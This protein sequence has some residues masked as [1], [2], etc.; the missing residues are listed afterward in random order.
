MARLAAALLCL[1]VA[2]VAAEEEHKVSALNLGVAVMLLGSIGFM[3]GVFYMVNHSDKDM[4]INTWKVICSTISIFVAV[5]MFQA[6]NGI[7]KV[8]FLEGASEEKMLVAAF[9]HAGFWF[10]FLQFFLAFVSGAVELPCVT[11]HKQEIHDNPVLKQKAADKLFLDMKCWAII[12]G[13]I[14]GFA[15]IGAWC[16]AQQF[17]KHSIGLSF[18]IVPLAAFVTW[19]AYKVSDMIRYRIA[20]GD[21]GVEDEFE[22]AWDE[23]TEETEDDVM[24]LTVSFLLVQAI[25]FSVVGVLPNEE[26]NF[27]EDIT[28]SDYQ[29]FM[30]V[31][32]GV[33]VGVFHSCALCSKHLG[34]LNAWVRLVCDFVF[35]WSLMFAIEAYLATHGLGGSVMGCIGEVVQANLVTVLSFAIIFILDKLAD[36]GHGG[37][38]ANDA[39][40][41][42][43][44]ALGILIGFSWEKCFDTAVDNTAESG[45]IVFP[46]AI[47]KLL[48]AIVLAAIVVPAWRWYILPVVKELGGFEE[49]EEEEEEE[50]HHGH[51]VEEGHGHPH[52]AKKHE[53]HAS[54]H[55]VSNVAAKA[56]NDD[57]HALPAEG[58][59]AKELEILK[60]FLQEQSQDR[61][62]L[63]RR[64]VELEA[65]VTSGV[66][67]Q[68]GA[69]A[70]FSAQFEGLTA[71]IMSKQ[72]YIQQLEMQLQAMS[73]TSPT[74]PLTASAAP[75][76]SSPTKAPRGV[77]MNVA[78]RVQRRSAGV[79]GVPGSMAM[80][81]SPGM[82]GGPGAGGVTTTYVGGGSY[83]S[84]P[85]SSYVAPAPGRNLPQTQAY[86][87]SP[88]LRRP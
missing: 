70:G 47:T 45:L 48:L 88:M 69:A 44:V 71:D 76:S 16:Q 53:G 54:S 31:S 80:P 59:P 19:T 12:L 24:G 20:M 39:I 28:V 87:S 72:A 77:P 18:A 29:V 8:T 65:A 11:S 22:K 52:E 81:T 7:V 13:H 74:E 25:R 33:V 1:L 2:I 46:P 32:I 5:L 82:P 38:K 79:P 51:H 40:R 15:C 84:Q 34:R 43:V 49:E 17:V 55:E 75:K 63:A 27:E 41:S 4:V 58:N 30:M 60:A 61:D 14:T 3:M 37:A 23:A 73:S 50:G 57:Y 42:T 56:V 64:V 66:E 10:L 21:D 68:R 67:T 35:S 6:I 36:A 86:R 83:V 62:S 85:T 26:G 9:L 78:G